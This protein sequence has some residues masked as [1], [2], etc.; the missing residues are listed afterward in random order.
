MSEVRMGTFDSGDGDSPA[1]WCCGY[2]PIGL[3]T[4]VRFGVRAAGSGWG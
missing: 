2:F 3:G 4:G 1:T